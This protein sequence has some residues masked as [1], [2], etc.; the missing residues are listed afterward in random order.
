VDGNKV[1]IAH[2]SFKCF[3]NLKDVYGGQTTPSNF[4]VDI[5]PLSASFTEGV[6]KDT[7][8]YVDEDRCNFIS[9]STTAAWF[10][11]GC[12]SACFSTGSGDYITSSITIADTKV[13]QTFV[14]GEEDLFVDVTSIISATLKNDLPDS[15][16]RISYPSTL[17]DDQKTYFVKRFGSRHSYDESKRPKLVVKFD[18][19]IQDDTSNLYLDSPAASNLFLYNYSNGQL[20]NLNFNNSEVTGSNCVLL[21]LQTE[22]TGVGTYTLYFTGSQHS[23]GSNYSTGIY[24]APVTLPLSNTNLRTTFEQTG[25]ISFKSSWLSLDESLAF[26]SGST[27][28]ALGP[29]RTTQRLS[30]R[31]YTVNALGT[32]SDYSEEEDV[33]MRVNI[34]DANSPIMIAQRLPVITPSIILRNSYYAIRN[35]STDEYEVP[36][37]TTHN[38]TR[39]SSDSA[40]MYFTFNTSALT[41]LQTYVIDVMITVEGKQQK[42]FNASAPFRIVKI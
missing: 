8:Y 42:Y 10:G 16:F 2:S 19:S 18:D 1:D 35:H 4:N 17:E 20:T 12:T 21:K 37:D 36:F 26:V 9:A 6:G 7:A 11:I 39:L 23:F 28:K 30:P 14:T 33:T 13:S 5:F 41:S 38:S 24:Y 34:F 15:G 31:R 25:S 27:V 40:G 3:L 29:E 32:S 22:V